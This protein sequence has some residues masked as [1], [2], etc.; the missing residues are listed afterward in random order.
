MDTLNIYRYDNNGLRAT[1]RPDSSCEQST[2]V[3]RGD[4]LPLTFTDAQYIDFRVGDYCT[5]FNTRY[6]LNVEAEYSKQGDRNWSYSMTM[7]GPYHQLGR[8]AF[9][10]LDR[11]NKLTLGKFNLRARPVDIVDLIVANMN[12]AFPGE[13]WQRGQVLDADYLDI[14]FDTQKCLQALS[15]AA[16]KFGTEFN[17]EGTTIH[18]IKRQ[19]SSG[20]TLEY[21][22]GKALW[23]IERKNA[24]NYTGPITRLYVYGSSKNLGDNY[25]NGAPYLQMADGLY[26]EKNV[27]L[28][29]LYEDTIYFDG[30]NGLPEIYPHR[31]GTVSAVTVNDTFTDTGIEFNVNDYLLPNAVPA[32]ITFNTGLLAGVTFVMHSFDNATKTFVIEPN[33]DDQT[34]TRPNADFK[35]AVG[36]TYV[37]TDIT[38]PLNYYTQAEADLKI[39]GQSWF[40]DNGPAKFIFQPGANAL[41]FEL[42][43]I[44]LKL[45]YSYTLSIPDAGLNRPIRVMGWSRNLRKPNLYTN[46]VLADA[47]VPQLPIVK[48]LNSI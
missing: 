25:R 34:N 29:G 27:N 8:V 20:I 33:T 40:K 10:T 23:S 14:P 37:I 39:A 28:S 47:V 45:G 26:L 43:G 2:G 15:T 19:P 1:I 24:D 6:R 48:I 21:G 32:K 16:D 31:T 38:L 17:I 4:Q 11:N 9:F 42:Q 13:G 7:E 35:P 30:T 46:L 3:M 12:R 5:V 18:L 41:Y 36:D 44:E 22:R